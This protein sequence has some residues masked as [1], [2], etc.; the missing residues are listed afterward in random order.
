MVTKVTAA[1]ELHMSIEE[2]LVYPLVEREEGADVRN[3]AEV[4][5]GLARDGIATL[6]NMVD[7]PGFGAAA[8]SLLGGLLHHVREEESE[9]FPALK[10][11]LDAAA[12]SEL[13]DQVAAAHAAGAAPTAV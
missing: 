11:K 9:I 12:W 2:T 1:L 6:N 5:H 13:G 10:D 8:E 3:E 7:E 4:E